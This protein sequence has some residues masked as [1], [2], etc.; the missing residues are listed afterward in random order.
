MNIRHEMYHPGITP[1]PFTLP[2]GL[3][4]RLPADAKL[5]PNFICEAVARSLMFSGSIPRE[6]YQGLN[7]RG[8]FVFTRVHP[9]PMMARM[10]RVGRFNGNTAN[11]LSYRV[12]F[13]R[14]LEVALLQ[15]CGNNLNRAERFIRDAIAAALLGE[16]SL[17][18]AEAD[19]LRRDHEVDYSPSA[20]IPG[21][22]GHSNR[23]VGRGDCQGLGAGD[24]MM[25][26]GGGR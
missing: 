11:P 10:E 26:R 18:R 5:R 2:A 7:D 23:M 19:Q 17:T 12:Q 24:D 16:K 22:S 6:Y 20:S 3:A 15:A 9:D 13:Q 4:F 25:R 14:G 8:Y 1:I 21:V